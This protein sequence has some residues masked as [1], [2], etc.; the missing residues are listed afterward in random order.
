MQ[1]HTQS[2]TAGDSVGGMGGWVV[3][4]LD[5]WLG[6]IKAKMKLRN[7]NK[8]LR[9]SHV[10]IANVVFFF[11]VLFFLYSFVFFIVV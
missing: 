5:W 3:G 1:P 2:I 7:S 10:S 9:D 8:N 4:R 6:D 11:K